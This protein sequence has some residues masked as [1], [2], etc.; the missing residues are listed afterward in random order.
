MKFYLTV[1][2]FIVLNWLF[3]SFSIDARGQ[4]GSS[5]SEKKNSPAEKKLFDTDEVIQI[6]L[7]GNIRELLNDRKENPKSH[8]LTVSYYQEDSTEITIQA[9]A[10]T[11]GHFRKLKENCYIPPLLIQFPDQ[12]TH[13]S[14]IFSDQKK[15]KLVMPCRED[16]YTV[17]E[18][19]VYKLYNLV[20]PKSFRSRLVKVL[21]E[22]V[23]NKKPS[24]PLYGL[25]LEE[26]RQVAKRNDLVSVER[27]LKPEQLQP[28]AFLNMAV[29]E[30][31][32]GNTDWSV[33]YL[34][35]VKLLAA[36]S[37]AVP[38][39]VPYDFDLAGIVFAPYARPAEELEMTSV[40]QRRYRGYCVNDMKVF[41]GIIARYNELKKDIYALYQGCTLLDAKYIKNTVK[42]LDDFY[43]TINNPKAWQ[44][45]FGYP[46]D[47]N[48]TGNVVIKGLR[49]E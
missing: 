18:W 39:P 24:T 42:Y 6:T 29:F 31:L 28:E 2:L 14:S 20:T 30:Y 26:E 10:K 12:G 7:R 48:G 21:M 38:A 45:E 43:E 13:L 22:D 11:R 19:L 46:C 25:L 16:E 47:K 5:M 37:L 1:R 4:A 32:V 8:P 9:E 44:R 36:D 3:F 15:I 17:R 23:N 40:R 41:D 27:R 49:E 33:Q 34:Q 35:N